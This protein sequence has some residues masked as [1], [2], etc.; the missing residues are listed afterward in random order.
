MRLYNR[1]YKGC[2][3]ELITYY[4]RYYRDVFEM[5][6]ILKAFGRISDGL[7]E[8]IEQ[9]Y[10]NNFILTADAETIKVWEEILEITYGEQ[11]TLDQRRRV[12][13]ARLMGYGHIGEPEIR[14]IIANYTENAVAVDFGGGVVFV[15]ID[16]EIFDEANLW[17]T[18]LKR[19]PAHLALNMKIHIQRTFRQRLDVH[20]G[21]AAGAHF[22]PLPVGEDRSSRARIYVG[23]SGWVEMGFKP[24]PVGEDRTSRTG[25][26]VA[27][28]GFLAPEQAGHYPDAKRASTGRTSGAG[29]AFYHTHTKSKLMG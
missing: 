6:E 29:G 27:Y 15:T 7:E 1:Y 26:S 12:V 22:S 16:G 4:P 21:G 18:L 24:G 19:I 10:L 5:V 23:N 11:L 28:G 14:A 2:Y 8:N 17:K 25:L 3:E 9:A 20:F 13:I